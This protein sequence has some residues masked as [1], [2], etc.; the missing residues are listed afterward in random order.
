MES[1][2]DAD[3]ARIP[4]TIWAIAAVGL[5]QTHPTLARF[6][7]EIDLPNIPTAR[8]HYGV[9]IVML[10]GK[11]N[12]T[13]YDFVETDGSVQFAN[14]NTSRQILTTSHRRLRLG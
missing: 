4:L 13:C 11:K 1:S 5:T 3:V 8:S 6:G 12:V 2:T 9:A 14:V 7:V 10:R